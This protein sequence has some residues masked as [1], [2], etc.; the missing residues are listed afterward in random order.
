[1]TAP[2]S[3]RHFRAQARPE[4]RVRIRWRR[5]DEHH[6]LEVEAQSR[7]I[8]V[9]GAFIVTE[10]PPPIGTPIEVAIASP[11]TWEPVRVR[12]LVRW[13]TKGGP[14]EDPGMGIE[15]QDL[16]P[17]DVVALH[18]FFVSLQFGGES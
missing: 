9:G 8:G 13:T 4:I 16:A 5:L 18:D 14:D 1:M 15:F 2:M 17:R 7:N 3:D 6:T 12:G 11:A 10:L